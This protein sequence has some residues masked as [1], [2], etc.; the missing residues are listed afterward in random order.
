MNILMVCLGNICR[1]PLAEGIMQS[2]CR[3]YDLDWYIDSAGTGYWHV[4]E[5]PDKRSVAIARKNNIDISCQ[6]ARQLNI[7]DFSGFDIIFAM[8][9]QNLRNILNLAKKNS[10]LPKIELILNHH[11]SPHLKNVP[12]P[13]YDGNFQLVFDLLYNACENFIRQYLKRTEVSLGK[14]AVA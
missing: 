14:E 6:V 5:N 8:D 11:D 4:G 7:N 12:D 2:L 1:S 3:Q 10:Q 9:E 13:Y